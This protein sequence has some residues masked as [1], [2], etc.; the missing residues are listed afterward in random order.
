MAR[1]RMV[2]RTIPTTNVNAFCV[3]KVDRTTFTQTFPIPGTMKDSE[4]CMK[5]LE[6]I[7][8]NEPIKPV[9]VISYEVEEKYYGMLE[10]DFI[11]YAKVL[12]KR[13]ETE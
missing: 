1:Q 3:N 10:Q 2:T 13:G 5:M 4:Q 6:K 9:D 7:L 11:K 12:P 8:K